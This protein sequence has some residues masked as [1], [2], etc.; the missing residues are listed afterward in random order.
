MGK[1]GDKS[2]TPAV[3]IVLLVIFR[4]PVSRSMRILILVP[5]CLMFHVGIVERL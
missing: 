1:N 2:F 3:C 4:F 5:F